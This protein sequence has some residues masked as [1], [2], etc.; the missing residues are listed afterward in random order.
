MFTVDH[1]TLHFQSIHIVLCVWSD[2]IFW[3]S[4]SSLSQQHKSHV[5]ETTHNRPLIDRKRKFVDTELAQDTEGNLADVK[6]Q[7]CDYL[8]K[9]SVLTLVGT[10][11]QYLLILEFQNSS[12]TSASCKRSGLQ[13]VS[14]VSCLHWA[15]FFKVSASVF[16][17]IAQK[18]IHLF[19]FSESYVSLHC[20]HLTGSFIM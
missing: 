9:Y 17:L 16:C 4:D 2:I 15:P 10:Y 12:K 3:Q 14:S 6:T 7:T 8:F 1:C 18:V 19:W 13:K 5:E 11:T 20:S